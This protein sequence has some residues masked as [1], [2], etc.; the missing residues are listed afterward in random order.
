[1]HDIFV[2]FESL[3]PA[4]SFREYMLS[5]HQNINFSVEHEDIGLLL[6]QMTKF[7]VKTVSLSLFNGVFTNYENFIWTYR[8][9]R[10]LYSL[11]L[12]WFQNISFG[13]RIIWRLFRKMTYPPSFTDS[14]IRLFLNNYASK[15]IFQN[16]SKKDIFLGISRIYFFIKPPFS[17][18]TSK[19]VYW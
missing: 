2:L 14:S 4:R 10:L 1:M 7:V 6:F 3:E 12:L 18:R 15:F 17:G 16:I 5:K 8:I 9:T 13:I 11:F 19:I